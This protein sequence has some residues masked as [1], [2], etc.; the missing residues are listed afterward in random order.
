MVHQ[1]LLNINKIFWDT[2]SLHPGPGREG[3]K[4]SQSLRAR[5][6]LYDQELL[7]TRYVHEQESA[8]NF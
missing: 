5:F 8:R 1:V 7:R 4:E 2:T 3:L 6:F